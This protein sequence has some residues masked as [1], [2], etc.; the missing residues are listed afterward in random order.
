MEEKICSK[1]GRNLPITEFY[2]RNKAAGIRRADCKDCH[3]GYVKQKY[4]DRH[5]E[6]QKIKESLK[7]AKCGENRYYVLDFHHKDPSIKDAGIAQMLRNN[8]SWEKIELEIKK[9]IPLCANCHRE[10][11][12][13]EREKQIKIEDYLNSSI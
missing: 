10:F 12:F 8:T 11:H 3:R 13:L 7:C 6:I 9:C 4:Q 1:C 2:W 5:E